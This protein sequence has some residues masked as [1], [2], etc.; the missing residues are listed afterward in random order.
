MNNAERKIDNEKLVTIERLCVKV[1]KRFA[2]TVFKHLTSFIDKALKTNTVQ[3]FVEIPLKQGCDLKAL[4]KAL[5]TLLARN[6]C[7]HC[8]EFKTSIFVKKSIAMEL[9][10]KQLFLNVFGK[11][12]SRLGI[13][14]VGDIAILELDNRD[15][16]SEAVLKQFAEQFLNNYKHVK[17][18]LLKTG[19]RSGEFRLQELKFLAGVNKTVT[20]HREHGCVFKVDV[21]KTY[22]SPRLAHERLRIARLVK[23]GE[24]VLVMFSGVAP[25]VVVIAKHS[26]P[27][28]VV[29]VE[30]NPKAHKLALENVKI[31]NLKPR[32]E[33]YCDDVKHYTVVEKRVFDRIV[34]P[35]PRDSQNF[36]REAV[37]LS[38]S[39]AVIHLYLFSSVEDLN[40]KIENIFSSLEALNV[41]L[42]LLNKVQAGQFASK[43]YRWCLDIELE[44]EKSS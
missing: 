11:P 43:Q 21:A 5:T 6:G 12:A 1:R 7:D 35:L 42:S 22:F 41:K 30:K 24:N 40:V 4:K 32:I 3:E 15:I 27:S 10:P 37:K 13:D 8:F 38:S 34:M 17:T 36:L 26:N 18:V 14:I 19:G 39:K 31:N 25:Y 9:S 2:N 23:H 16:A 28:L 20:M 44:K 33:L 29:G